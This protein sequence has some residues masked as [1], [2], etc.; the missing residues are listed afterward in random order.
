MSY[1]NKMLHCHRPVSK[2]WCPVDTQI[3]APLQLAK[4]MWKTNVIINE[5]VCQF[6]YRSFVNVNPIL[7]HHNLD[8]IP[9]P[10]QSLLILWL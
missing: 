4:M 1:E 3:R 5:E 7:I 2:V 8:S 10:N 6:I 9:L